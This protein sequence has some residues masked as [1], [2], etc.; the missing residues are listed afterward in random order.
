M[1]LTP[2]KIL[3][4]LKLA[5]VNIRKNMKFY[6]PYLCTATFTVMMFYL[7]QFL[8]TNNGIDAMGPTT[9]AGLRSI[10]S[11]GGIVIA[12]FSMIFL[13]YTNSFV[14]KRRKKELGVFHVLGMEKRH[15]SIMMIIE[16]T[17]IS[18]T[19]I[20]CGLGLGILFSKLMLLFLYQLVK[21][22]AAFGFSV[23]R[24]GIVYTLVLFLVIFSVNL[25]FNLIQIAVTKPVNLLTGSNV[26][27]KEPRTKWI[28]TIIGS[29]CMIAGYILA[30]TIDSPIKALSVFFTAVLLVIAGTYLL[31]IAVSI[32]VMKVLKKNKKFYYRAD[33]FVSLSGMLYR[34]KQNAAGLASIC[35]LSTMVIIMVSTTVC[36][37]VGA[38]DLLKN[39]YPNDIIIDVQEPESRELEAILKVTHGIEKEMNLQATYESLSSQLILLV[40]DRDGKIEPEYGDGA[41]EKREPM[42]ASIISLETYRQ[43][44][45][46]SEAEL[47]DGEVL[48]Y[49][50]KK[51]KAGETMEILGTLYTVKEQIKKTELNRQNYFLNLFD[52]YI[53]VVRDE[54]VVLQ[55]QETYREALN[56]R[57]AETGEDV[58]TYSEP[59]I[60]GGINIDVTGTDEEKIELYRRFGTAINAEIE[61]VKEDG[62]RVK[63]VPN[64]SIAC[65]AVSKSTFQADYGGLLFLGIFL[66]ITFLMATVLI[67]YYKQITEGYDDQRRFAIMQQV[68]MSK[69]EVKRTIR[70]QVML[71]FFL[72][73]ATAVCHIAGSF[74]MIEKLLNLLNLTNVSLFVL[75]TVITVIGFG[76]FYVLIYTL[77]ARVYY[78]I[79]G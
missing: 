58:L 61:I 3:F 4:Y 13:F 11:F 56:N 57:A 43:Y 60:Y 44:S 23:S 8:A 24:Q 40:N 27:E 73:L 14:I 41:A 36:M 39:R 69:A 68:G 46:E 53:I 12:I 48:V 16:N 65:Q 51:A 77:T 26:G 63:K 72:P 10:F 22:K 75:F 38:E 20:L 59:M 25:I 9:A 18:A 17:I 45:G 34:M 35:I 29:G 67:I 76:L 62:T 66:G 52:M 21:I 42:M 70:S 49:A 32:T 50:P 28:L 54:D 37:Y 1:T 5:V 6:F 30:N 79:V 7:F 2:M 47:A 55:M 71:V 74:R 33:R 19:S 15:L 64:V 31:F 78:K